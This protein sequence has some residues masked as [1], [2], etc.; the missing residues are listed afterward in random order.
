ME[1]GLK[2]TAQ[3]TGEVGIVEF[4]HYWWIKPRQIFAQS[5]KKRLK[6]TPRKQICRQILLR[7]IRTLMMRKWQ[8][9]KHGCTTDQKLGGGGSGS[10]IGWLQAAHQNPQSAGRSEVWTTTHAC[11]PPIDRRSQLTVCGF[12]V[13]YTASQKNMPP[14]FCPFLCYMHMHILKVRPYRI[15]NVGALGFLKR[16]TPT[17]TI[18]TTTRW[19]TTWDQFLIK[20]NRNR[21]RVSVERTIILQLR[22][23][24]K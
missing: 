15:W 20:K 23:D 6:V 14:N 13:L 18:T 11:S 12:A 8:K 22:S 2:V 1:F 19:V 17:R 9:N 4:G 24:H 7:L 5:L 16:A 21:A 3:G 10:V